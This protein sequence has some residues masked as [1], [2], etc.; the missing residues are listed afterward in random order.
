M[1]KYTYEAK[2]LEGKLVKG[3]VDAESITEARVKIRSNQFMPM[4]IELHSSE[5]K[6]SGKAVK[7]DI[8]EMKIFTRQFA[9]LM[10]AGVPIIESL[11]AMTGKARSPE[12][13]T[14]L[15]GLIDDIEGGKRLA[16]SMKSYPGAFDTMYVNLVTAG[17][18]GGVLEDVL[19]RLAEYIEKAV[20]LKRKV[21]GALV[22]P[23]A[24]L[25]IAAVVVAAILFFVVPAFE[26]LFSDGGKELPALTQLVIDLSNFVKARWYV[27]IAAAFGIPTVIKKYYATKAGK[28]NIDRIL[29]KTPLFGD[30]ILKSSVARFTRTL[31]TLIMSGV[32]VIESLDIAA[33]T[34]GNKVLENTLLECKEYISQGKMLSTPLQNS[35]F[36][37]EM[38][39]Q[40]I[41]IGEQ[42]GSLDTMLG[43]V[44]DFY[45]EEVE[46]AADS[47]TSMI[48]PIMM[49]FLGVV[50]GGLV[51][52]M[53]LPVFNLADA[54]GA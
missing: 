39:S 29:L 45:E 13:N 30:L 2:T 35:P 8:D 41:S 54:V 34:A 51:V 49:A 36:I 25:V 33:A 27:I 19:K 22:Y 21:K 9:V 4:L 24:I 1:P 6:K 18:E 15:R 48:E 10:G 53:Y 7:V 42:S 47:L 20:A 43:K 38:V 5:K 50:V 12:L 16:E 40:M 28:E 11:E 32:R 31:S 52:A 37:P 26:K 46:V 3:T 44:A 23:I 17:E 14:V